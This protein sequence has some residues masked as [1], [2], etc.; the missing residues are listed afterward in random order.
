MSR[1]LSDTLLEETDLKTIFFKNGCQKVIEDKSNI[2]K[3]LK[4]LISHGLTG[5]KGELPD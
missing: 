1:A 4:D 2:A 3:L 5:I